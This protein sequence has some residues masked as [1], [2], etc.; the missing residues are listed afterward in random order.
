MKLSPKGRFFL[1]GCPRSGTTLLQSLLAAHPE[2]ASFPESYFFTRLVPEYE[3]RRFA[4]G[5]ASKR[6]KPR[7]EQFLH[8]I[9]RPEMI[10][11]LPLFA[12]SMSQY[13]R[14]FV[15]VLDRV[16]EEQGKRIWIEKTP[17]HLYYIDY[18]ENLIKQVKFLH[19]IRNGE[20]VVASLYEVTHQHP[21]AW[22]GEL[23]ID[24]CICQWLKAIQVSR[25]YL[26]KAN[27][28][29]VRYEHLV[30]APES[31]LTR[32]CKFLGVDFNQSMLESYSSTAKQVILAREPWKASV[33][34]K[35]KNANSKKFYELFTE[36]QRQYIIDKLREVNLNDFS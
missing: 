18:I 13:T 30:E 23:D 3:P 35:I 20:D 6:T 15:E 11:I 26:S 27:H 16:T 24:E 4:L 31:V 36:K 25:T 34:G 1:V 10:K 21:K 19:I 29:F 17:R 2:I 9:G 14:T 32:I 12:F 7:F 33:S 28:A 22:L 8:D 5:I